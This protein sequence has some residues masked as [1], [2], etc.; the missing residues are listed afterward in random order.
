MQTDNRRAWVFF[1]LLSLIWG[2]SFLLM[3]VGVEEIPPAQLT[4]TRVGIA[5]MGM[6]LL[7]LVTRRRYP[8]DWRT[9][10]ALAIIGFGNS[11]LPFTL[12]AWA[13]AYAYAACDAMLPGSFSAPINPAG[14]RSWTELLF[15][16][17]AVLSSV[18]LSDILPATG[19]A[20]SLVMLESF[21]GVM[22]M[23]LVVSRLVSL[24]LLRRDQG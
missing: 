1:F 13:F 19:M 21:A 8:T 2:S 18:G 5:A 15:L 16:S 17:V 20:R 14:P 11:A 22:Y 6:N 23:A 7:M 24:T 3:R 12:L 9:L 4:F 10:G